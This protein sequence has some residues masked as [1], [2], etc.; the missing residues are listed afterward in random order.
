MNDTPVKPLIGLPTL[1][2]MSL[3]GADLTPLSKELLHRIEADPGDT[4]AMMDFSII[5]HLTG[6]PDVALSMQA[7]ALK[8]QP[9]YHFPAASAP[10]TVRVLAIMVPG[11][12]MANTPLEFLLQGSDIALD[13]LYV[14]EGARL[15]ASLPAHDLLFIAVADSDRTRPLLHELEHIVASWPCPVLNQPSRLALLS[16]A[17]ASNLLTG[18]AGVDMPLSARITRH[19]LEAVAHGKKT[20]RHLIEDGDFP[21]IIRPV[22]SQAGRGLA[23]LDGAQDITAYLEGETEREF[24][25]ARFVDYRGQDGLFRKFRIIFID[26]RPFIA[27]MAISE[28]W[29]IH[30]LNAGMG[31]SEAKRAEEASVMAVFNE[32]FARHHAPAMEA[33]VERM[34][35]DYFGIDCAQTQ[36]GELLVFE[37]DSALVVHA[38]DSVETYAYKQP[39][40]QKL[41]AAFR[42]MLV[43]RMT[44]S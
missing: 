1:M 8:I 42:N 15:P 43:R 26:G 4:N 30:Y 20:I 25:L 14:G 13:M 7:Q 19:D 38:M 40:M 12:L 9:L 11:E 39:Q 17:D 2:H 16:R 32:D 6:I 41:F 18:I 28:H 3:S 37:I 5:M 44:G 29:M 10:A 22:D 31:E 21:V 24:Y 27:H 23:K 36:E 34:G 33:I 35:L